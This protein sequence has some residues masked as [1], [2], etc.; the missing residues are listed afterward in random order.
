MRHEV[1]LTLATLHVCSHNTL[2]PRHCITELALSNSV[3]VNKCRLAV[4]A[5]PIQRARDVFSPI[6]MDL[7]SALVG[8]CMSLLLNLGGIGPEPNWETGVPA[9]VEWVLERGVAASKR[10][11]TAVV[12][13]STLLERGVAASKRGATAVV[14]WSTLLERGVAAVAEIGTPFSAPCFAFFLWNALSC[15]PQEQDLFAVELAWEKKEPCLAF[16]HLS[17]EAISAKTSL[18]EGFF[19]LP[20]NAGCP[21]AKSI[22]SSAYCWMPQKWWDFLPSQTRRTGRIVKRERERIPDHDLPCLVLLLR[23]LH[24]ILP[25]TYDLPYTYYLRTSR[26]QYYIIRARGLPSTYALPQTIHRWAELI[27]CAIPA[28][29]ETKGASFQSRSMCLISMLW[30]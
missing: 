27:T 1:L 11:A 9:V 25:S 7:I 19:P 13:W 3:D 6:L 16:L 12:E 5:S 24:V 18:F 17:I 21:S 20:A 10:G 14:E 26:E 2:W 23:Y 4:R 15:Q 28:W 22:S 29:S 30:L 8:D